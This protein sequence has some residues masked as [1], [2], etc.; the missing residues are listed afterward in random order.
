ME[1]EIYKLGDSS[2]YDSVSDAFDDLANLYTAPIAK[3]LARWVDA[4]SRSRILDIG[5]G[6]G[7]VSRELARQSDLGAEVV[8]IDLSKGMLSTAEERARLTGLADRLRFQRADAEALDL[9]DAC[10]D[11]YVSLYAYSHF[12][13]PDRAAAEAF[14]ILEPGGRLAVAIGSGPKLFSAQGIARAGSRAG[15]LLSELRGRELNACDHIVGLVRGHLSTTDETMIATWSA[16]SRNPT[17]RLAQLIRQAGFADV[18]TDW[19]GAD[20]AIPTIE[21]FWVLQTTL[22]TWSRKYMQRANESELRALKTAFWN[23]CSKVQARG[24][25]LMYRIGAGIVSARKP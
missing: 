16:T 19:V 18:V 14:R 12:P 21:E 3:S 4:T 20:I 25:R 5:C 13:N 9:P 7:I 1:D 11:G 10:S 22:S 15:R 24:G 6:T 2:S 17:P 23:D 8:G